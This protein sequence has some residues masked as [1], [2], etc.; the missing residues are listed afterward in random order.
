MYCNRKINLILLGLNNFNL[1]ILWF[2]RLDVN[3]FEMEIDFASWELITASKELR[4]A[5]EKL[6]N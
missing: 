4:F 2:R 5:W 1:Y 6:L 3:Q